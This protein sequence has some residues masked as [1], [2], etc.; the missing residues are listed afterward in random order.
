MTISGRTTLVTL[1]LLLSCLAPAQEPA[2]TQ[3]TVCE[4]VDN[5][6]KYNGKLVHVRAYVTRVPHAGVIAPRG[7]RRSTESNYIAL[8]GPERPTRNSERLLKILRTDPVEADVTGTF[9]SGGAFGGGNCCRFELAAMRI[10]KV[11]KAK[12][13]PPSR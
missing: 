5:P 10:E 3:A 6:T 4:L 13:T 8:T 12:A 11:R 7:C 1:L 9:R 2:V